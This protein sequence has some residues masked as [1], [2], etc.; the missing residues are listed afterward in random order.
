RHEIT[1]RP[2]RWLADSFAFA[3]RGRCGLRLL[4][5]T[6]SPGGG[7]LALIHAY[8]QEHLTC[9]VFFFRRSLYV[10]GTFRAHDSAPHANEG[11]KLST[12][13]A[14]TT[15]KI[16]NGNPMPTHDACP[17]FGAA[18]D[19]PSPGDPLWREKPSKGT[20]GRAESLLSEPKPQ[21]RGRGALSNATSRFEK[22]IR[23]QEK[24]GWDLA[25]EIP[26]LRTQVTQ[27]RAKT[28]ITQNDSPDI[29]FDRS[30]NPYRG[31][32]HGCVYCYAR[33][34]HA[35]LGLSPGLDFESKLFA[36]T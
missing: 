19:T 17:N 14:G 12:N 6:Q 3:P 33:P 22:E 23:C 35:F 26:P 9:G 4:R 13:H 21:K 20:T 28:I 34:T 24:D 15:R 27:E 1:V 36:K 16:K 7:F 5:I 29:S 31:C 32:E 11:S 18:P 2:R 25:E 10:H 8:P 30:I